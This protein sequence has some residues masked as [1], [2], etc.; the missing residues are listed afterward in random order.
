MPSTAA[1]NSADANTSGMPNAGVYQF[2]RRGSRARSFRNASGQGALTACLDRGTGR[3]YQRSANKRNYADQ[4]MRSLGITGVDDKLRPRLH[5]LRFD[6]AYHVLT[7]APGDH[8]AVSRHMVALTTYL[9]HNDARNS[10]WYL[11]ATPALFAKIAEDCENFANGGN[12]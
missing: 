4:L 10:Y 9:G 3:K 6:F 11:E 5:D 7:N 1:Q 12:P 8:S 2:A